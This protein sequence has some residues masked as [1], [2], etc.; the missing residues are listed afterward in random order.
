MNSVDDVFRTDMSNYPSSLVLFGTGM[1]ESEVLDVV[2]ASL[3]IG[4]G[5][6]GASTIGHRIL[7]VDGEFS[8][9][10][11]SMT[12]CHMP[13]LE[14]EAVVTG[15]EVVVDTPHNVTICPESPIHLIRNRSR[16]PVAG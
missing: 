4:L 10:E 8:W 3:G 11:R 12:V 16:R 2:C 6:Q 1:C 13:Q 15:C 5:H 14:G 9:L 7:M